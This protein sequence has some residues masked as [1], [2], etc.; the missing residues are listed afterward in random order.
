M[1]YW[2]RVVTQVVPAAIV[3]VLSATSWAIPM[4]YNVGPDVPDVPGFAGSYLHATSGTDIFSMNCPCVAINGQITLD[5]DNLASAS[6]Q[7][8]GNGTLYG[9]TGEWT[10]DITGAGDTGTFGNGLD[11]LLSLAYDVLFD[12]NA[13]SSGTFYFAR[14]DF[15]GPAD[16]SPNSIDPGSRMIL[17]GNNWL[18]VN[19]RAGIV[20]SHQFGIDLFATR[21]PEPAPGALLIGAISLVL[22]RRRLRS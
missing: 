13:Y 17:W 18:D 16:P 8:S 4:T 10:I 11:V 12:G 6:G 15:N 20:G 5:F 19:E 14:K 1:K 9:R 2:L 22:L 21:V 3:M 7:M